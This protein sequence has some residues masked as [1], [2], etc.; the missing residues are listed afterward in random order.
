M[1]SPCLSLASHGEEGTPCNNE[2][3]GF[4]ANE[5]RSD[6]ATHTHTRGWGPLPHKHSNATRLQPASLAIAGGFRRTT[7]AACLCPLLVIVLGRLLCLLFLVAGLCLVLAHCPWLVISFIIASTLLVFFLSLACLV[8]IL[9]L[10]FPIL[11]LIV[12]FLVLLF[13]LLII[14]VIILLLVLFLA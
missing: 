11:F 10:V 8:L 9:F 7:V 13:L 1:A 2:D 5:W 12:V 14:I 3:W 4:A 6:H